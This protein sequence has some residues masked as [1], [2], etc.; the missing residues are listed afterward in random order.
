MPEPLDLP[1][2]SK[3]LVLGAI[4]F[5]G[6]CAVLLSAF[7][8]SEDW[9]PASRGFLR[10]VAG[11][12]ILGF[13]MCAAFVAILLRSKRWRV[14]VDATG[15]SV[16]TLFGRKSVPWSDIQSAR[17]LGD[18]LARSLLITRSRGSLGIQAVM[19]SDP[20][21]FAQVASAVQ[22]YIPSRSS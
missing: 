12:A 16:D 11:G 13:V 3:R 5:F 15:I 9:T 17:V 21:H 6:I 20:A 19:M 8:L 1:Y 14:R 10:L 4:A 18:G 22:Q 7:A 2:G